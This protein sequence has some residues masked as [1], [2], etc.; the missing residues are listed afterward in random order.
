MIMAASAND[1]SDQPAEADGD[2]IRDLAKR[3]GL[4][5]SR[6]LDINE[7]GLDFQVATGTD[8]SGTMWLLRIPRRPSVWQRAEQEARTLQFLKGRL[9]VAVPDWRIATPELIAYPLLTDKT[10]ITVDPTTWT[11]TWNIDQNSE[12]FVKSLG[13]TLAVLHNL[14]AEEATAAGI[15]APTIDEIRA[16]FAQNVDR[17]K[18][19]LGISPGLEQRWRR[20]IDDDTSWPDFTVLIHGDLYVG[21]I[22]VGDDERVTGIIDWTEATMGDSSHDFSGH[23]KGFGEQGLNRLIEAYE[24]WGGRTWPRMRHHIGEQMSAFSVTYAVFALDTDDPRHLE[25]VKT[26]LGVG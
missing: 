22:L 23:L 14:P 20:W 3:H 25:A 1:G 17:V 26:E 15:K 4:T 13:E 6:G 7:I 21:H 2:G 18:D 8:E 11:P 16:A 10:A 9:P 5:L 12:T 19:E 24:A